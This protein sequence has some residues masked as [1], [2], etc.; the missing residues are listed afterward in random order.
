MGLEEIVP[1]IGEPFNPKLQECKITVS[2]EQ[3]GND[4]VVS[5]V[6]R[7]YIDAKTG[8]ILRYVGVS[9]NKLE[10]KDGE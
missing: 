1:Q 5:L 2:E 9:V 3:Y 8:N 7:G 4:I 6:Q 10:E